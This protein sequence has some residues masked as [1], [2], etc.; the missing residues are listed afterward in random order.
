MSCTLMESNGLRGD[1]S[2]NSCVYWSLLGEGKARQYQC[3]LAFYGLVGPRRDRL[4]RW[5]LEFKIK[6]RTE[7]GRQLDKDPYA[8]SA[9]LRATEW[10]T[11]GAGYVAPRVMSASV[12]R[13]SGASQG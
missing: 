8:A 9:R 7:R 3:A 4:S 6:A 12:S 1:C 5:L 2:T 13:S 10:S 11:T